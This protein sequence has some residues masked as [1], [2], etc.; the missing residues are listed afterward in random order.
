MKTR[1]PPAVCAISACLGL[2]LA[3]GPTFAHT[4]STTGKT[5]T[6]RTG[7]AGKATS[8]AFKGSGFGSRI[9]GGQAPGASDTTAYQAIGCT[10]RSGKQRVNDVAESALPGLGTISHSRTRIWTTAKH[11]VVASHATHSISQIVLASTGVGSLSIDGIKSTSTASHDSSGFHP[12]TSTQIGSLVLTPPVGSP[13]SLP[14]PTPDQPITIPGLAT[15]YAG[16]SHT[17]RSAVGAKARAFALRIDVVATGSTIRIAH[18]R[19]ELNSG[20][21]GGIFGGH[22]AATHVVSAVGDVLKGGRQPLN[23]MPCQGTYGKVL[24]KR[25]A[26]L[27]LGGQLL[28]S[29]ASTRGRAVQGAHRAHGFERAHIGSFDLGGGQLLITDIVAKAS[30]TRTAHGVVKSAKGTQL[31]S[32]TA[33]GQTQKFPKTGV[34]EIPGVAKLERAVVTRSH[35]GISVIGLRI[36]LLDGTGAVIN[37]AEAKLKIHPRK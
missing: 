1:I 3:T 34:L 30:V 18:S 4:P 36:T 10:N 7:T 21:T 28:T 35:S 17:S 14:L 27:D 9:V 13:Q 37:L 15:I 31:G 25:L 16:K 12:V 8:F 29:D 32:V 26:T 23:L 20:V 5:T 11:G 2:V 24:K 6:S 22:S 33:N 19:A